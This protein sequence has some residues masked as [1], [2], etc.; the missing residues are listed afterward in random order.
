MSCVYIEHIYE[1]RLSNCVGRAGT[2]VYCRQHMKQVSMCIF[3]PS[4]KCILCCKEE[5]WNDERNIK[6][7]K[8]R[9]VV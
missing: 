6:A 8:L 9:N 2:V 7:L 3:N 4:K 5:Q 1:H